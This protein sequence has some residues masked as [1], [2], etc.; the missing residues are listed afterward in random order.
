MVKVRTALGEA[1][2]KAS[3]KIPEDDTFTSKGFLKIATNDIEHYK[4]TECGNDFILTVKDK[5]WYI[6]K[7]LKLPKRCDECIKKKVIL[8]FEEKN[9]HICVECGQS[10]YMSK[11][12]EEWYTSKKL[13][14][15]IRCNKCVYKKKISKDML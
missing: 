9:E 5:N 14:I 3:I 11:S 8:D 4:C 6:G 12:H 13:T 10:F 15:P 7:G 2:E 1:L